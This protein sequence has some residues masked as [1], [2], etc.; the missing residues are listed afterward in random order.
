M[1]S[2]L[3][4]FISITV[5]LEQVLKI[6]KILEDGNHFFMFTK[7]GHFESEQDC[8]ANMEIEVTL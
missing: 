1:L 5:A 6:V 7:S 4:H 8:F 2:V 3:G